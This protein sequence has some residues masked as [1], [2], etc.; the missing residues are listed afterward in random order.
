MRWLKIFLVIILVMLGLY[1]VSMHYFVDESKKFTVEKEI[2]YPI[3]KVFPQFN[4]FQNFT[5]WN[6]YF[7]ASK[8]MT[9]DYYSPYS[10]KDSSISFEEL[11]GN[12][13]GEMF[14][15]YSN[16][17]RTLRYQLYEGKQKHPTLIDI[18]FI[19]VS[20]ELT[21][22]IWNVHTPKKSLLNRV[23]NLWTEE[24][25]IKNLDKSFANLK[26]ILGN[27]VEKETFLTDIKYDSL[28]VETQEGQ[29]ILGVN[30]TTG[31]RKKDA[32][33]KNI[34][35]NHNKVTNFVSNDLD[36]RDDEFGFPV[37]ITNPKDYKDK[38]V[39]YF[40]GIPLSKREAVSDN[41]FNFRTINESQNYVIYYKGDYN[42]RIKSIQQLL[43]KA[44]RDSMRNG[45]LQQV[46]L[47]TPEE[48]K[49][50]LIKISLPVYR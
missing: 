27:K 39:S 45:A 19:P 32:L 4:N 22:T 14:I 16:I 25:F 11:K 34:I 21:K 44:K 6:N 8:T 12:K 33:F 28:M 48:G 50:V 23:K 26:N 7:A 20:N 18:K 35:I 38:E 5:R 24:D 41:N 49:D 40:I 3:D 36:K 43:Q 10:G 30:V 17:N 31:N 42:N 2:S 1:T 47:E 15:K 46:F 13:S 9:I 29:L 37:L